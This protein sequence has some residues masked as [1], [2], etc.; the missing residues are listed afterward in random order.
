VQN[1]SAV[2][3]EYLD[4]VFRRKWWIVVPTIVG[5]LFAAA[6]YMQF[7]KQYKAKTR[8]Q[9]RSQQISRALLSP[10]VESRPEEL[11]NSIGAEITSEQ[12]MRQLDD[13]LKLVGTPRGPR[14][15]SELAKLIEDRSELE[16]NIRSRYFDLTIRWGDPKIAAAVA[17]ELAAIYMDA[18]QEM[19]TDLADTTLN[20]L[21]QRRQ[22]IQ[23]KLEGVR[24]SIGRLQTEHAQ[25]LQSFTNVHL[26]QKQS[27]DREIQRLDAEVNRLND[28][29]DEIDLQMRVP[30]AATSNDTLR[31]PRFSQLEEA[32]RRLTD[33]KTAGRTEEFPEVKQLRRRIESLKNELGV[34]NQDGE[35]M[36]NPTELRREQLRQE[37]VQA[38]RNIDIAQQQRAKYVRDNQSIDLRLSNTPRWQVEL[39]R[40]ETEEEQ[41]SRDFEEWRKKESDALAGSTVEGSEAG[42]KLVVLNKATAPATAFW[43]DLKMFLLMGFAVGAGLGITIV[44]LLEVFDQSFKSE[45]QL[46]ASIDLPILAVIPDLTR[47]ENLKRGGRRQTQD[48]DAKAA[49]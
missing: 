19:R 27:N 29:I 38:E 12:Y 30:V 5:V 36:L 3:K 42:E 17:N 49:V 34:A 43:P 33:L 44:L 7:P 35:Q 21:R 28:R 9:A 26:Q 20:Q 32:E 10:T 41:L 40:L 22:E 11:V 24:A 46:A 25:E 23:T 37:R 18:A 4:I 39:S 8:V 1:N 16:P 13:R 6:L 47:A 15:L 48:R 14:D 45:E 31:D 2:L